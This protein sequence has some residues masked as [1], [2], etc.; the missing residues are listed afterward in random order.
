MNAKH[1][2]ADASRACPK[3][4]SRVFAFFGRPEGKEEPPK[5]LRRFSLSPLHQWDLRLRLCLFFAVI[6]AASWLVSAF[7]VWAES[8]EYKGYI[9]DFYDTQQMFLAKR[10]T[11]IDFG[12]LIRPLPRRQ[13]SVK[14]GIDVNSRF[15]KET[16]SFAVFSNDGEI[17]LTDDHKGGEGFIFDSK[18]RGFANSPVA[19]SEGLWRI[20]WTPSPDGN[21]VIA[22]GQ[23][24]D[25]REDIF[26]E[27]LMH[28]ILPWILLVPL[29]LIG[30]F[31]ALSRE[32]KPLKEVAQLL[33]SRAPE[34]TSPL[35]PTREPPEVRPM[36]KALNSLFSRIG[37]MLQRER[38]FISDAAHELRTPLTALR[39]QAEV[40]GLA[41]NDKK[42]L[43]RAMQKLL[44]GIDNST[45]LVEQLLMLS[46]LEAM[47]ASGATELVQEKIDWLA[48][49][50]ELAADHKSSAKKKGIDLKLVAAEE[51]RDFTAYPVLLAL[52]LRN[53][54]DNAVKYTPHGGNIFI[55]LDKKSLTIEN[56]GPGVPDSFLPRLCERFSRP[57]GQ[58]GPGSG[59][60]LA[61]A[62]RAADINRLALSLNNR[63]RE[64]GGG[65][66]AR[67]TFP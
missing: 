19:G 55:L 7:V 47:H 13:A 54:L 43:E 48:I 58:A 14:G 6:L 16:L 44:C 33:E 61:I 60:G 53:L 25:Q 45:Q 23:E 26:W 12:G 66:V 63:P 56:S 36:V 29:L 67:L 9:N 52:L 21:F 38:A 65:F 24:L 31:W 41:V 11:D 49:L 5:A 22:V 32:L 15:N 51:P 39:V 59:L 40:A 62:K 42:E 1:S 2:A 4:F 37:E 46:R 18:R 8:K 34:D 57:R 28:Q 35:R 10:L 27:M 30:L 50:R 3:P 17:V 20:F 64:Q